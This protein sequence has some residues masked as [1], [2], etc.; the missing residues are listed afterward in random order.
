MFGA[1][2]EALGLNEEDTKLRDA[3]RELSRDFEP[4]MMHM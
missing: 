2:V 3:I 1:P 4:P